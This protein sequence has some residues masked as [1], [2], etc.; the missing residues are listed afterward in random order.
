MHP[1]CLSGAALLLLGAGS[2]FD[3]YR[4]MN[5]QPVLDWRENNAQVGRIGGWRA[6]AREAAT[7][8]AAASATAAPP[9]ASAPA[10]TRPRQADGRT[11]K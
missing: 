5:D 9:A 7:A 2:A 4:P 1:L 10:S 8:G 11:V 3:G 6:Y